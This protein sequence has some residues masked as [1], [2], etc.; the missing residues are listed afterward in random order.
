MCCFFWLLALQPHI[1][2]Q[3]SNHAESRGRSSRRRR[4]GGASAHWAPVAPWLPRPRK[5]PPRR[6]AAP[7]GFAGVAPIPSLSNSW[8]VQTTGVV[9][10]LRVEHPVP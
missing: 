7:P 9:G 4:W 5:P 1:R 3:C 2:H 8:N 10:I 6:S